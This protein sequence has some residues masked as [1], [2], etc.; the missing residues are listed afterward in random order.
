MGLYTKYEAKG[1]GKIS[2][3][4]IE[5]NYLNK[6]IE[7]GFFFGGGGAAYN[8][9]CSLSMV[10]SGPSLKLHSFFFKYVNFSK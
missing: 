8:R 5:G 2:F 7:A 3:H 4:I 10:P 1:N 9:G 6:M